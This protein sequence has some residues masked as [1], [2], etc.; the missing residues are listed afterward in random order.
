MS[1]TLSTAGWSTA[2]IRRS[3]D[4]HSPSSASSSELAAAACMKG[5]PCPLWAHPFEGDC[6]SS[7]DE[8]PGCRALVHSGAYMNGACYLY[9]DKSERHTVERQPDAKQAALPKVRACV[10]AGGSGAECPPPARGASL[11]L[12]LV[13]RFETTNLRDWMY[14]HSHLGV[15]HYVIVS[16][17]CDD[18]THA[19]LLRVAASAPCAPKVSFVNSFR[20]DTGFQIHAYVEAVRVLLDAGEPPETRVGFWDVDEFL[21]VHHHRGGDDGDDDDLTPSDGEG[22]AAGGGG[23]LSAVDELFA[24][25]PPDTEQW[26]FEVKPFGPSMH[27][28]APLGFA[29]ANFVLGSDLEPDYYGA[30]PK[31]AC[32]LGAMRAALERRAGPFVQP[33]MAP[34]VKHNWPHHCLPKGAPGHYLVPRAAARLNHYATR[35]EARWRQKC[36]ELNPTFAG[37]SRANK[38][39]CHE[40]GAGSG[41][42]GNARR[43]GGMRSFFNQ[44]NNH[45]DLDLFAELDRRGRAIPEAFLAR[46]WSGPLAARVAEHC[47]EQRRRGAHALRGAALALCADAL[48]LTPLEASL[49]RRQRAAAAAAAVCDCTRHHGGLHH[50]DWEPRYRCFN[51]GGRDD[52]GSYCWLLCCR[53]EA[54]AK[55]RRA[56]KRPQPNG[57][58]ATAGRRHK[59]VAGAGA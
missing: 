36:D 51:H 32:R 43:P 19:E 14:Y 29:P 49:R 12:V 41:G 34:R 25:G 4:C 24:L 9:D 1:Q 16:N 21:V 3:Y 37:L 28:A 40:A 2:P 27:V 50:A 48:Q 31:S 38:T 13:M 35:H 47:V 6:R 33:A 54:T 30:F 55:L 53:G 17:E 39:F 7:C 11:V 45:T 5:V 8:M 20:C 42:G 56:S 59:A 52:D 10:A 44:L 15:R 23:V 22:T 26:T 57:T 46:A 58:S 18:A